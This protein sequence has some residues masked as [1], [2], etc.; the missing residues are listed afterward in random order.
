MRRIGQILPILFIV[1]VLAVAA[2]A[3]IYLSQPIDTKQ[4]AEQPDARTTAEPTVPG[5]TPV[6]TGGGGETQG[7]WFQLY[8]NSPTYPDDPEAHRGGLDEKLVALIDRAQRSVDVAAYDFDLANVADALVRAQGRGVRVRMV[9]DSDIVANDDEAIQA[10]FGKLKA[11]RIPVIEDG[12]KGIMH[13]K[14]TV[15]DGRWVSTGSWNYTDG[16]T[17]RLNNVMIVIESPE[18]ATN[19][20]TEFAKMF[21]RRQFGPTKDKMIPNPVVTIGGSRIETCFASQNRCEDRIVAALSGSTRSIR[22]LAFSFTSTPI[23]QAMLDRRAT[24]VSLAGVFETTGSDTPYSAYGKLKKQGVEV[25]TDGNPYAMHHKA[26]IIDERIVIFGSY[27]FSDNANTN[28]DENLL[29][30]DNPQIARAF[31]AEYERVLAVAKNPPKRK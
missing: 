8:F 17:Y 31:L 14:F 24:G 23:T 28:N 7:G 26:I 5:S 10:A 11:A 27:N 21:E 29:I 13:H 20:S 1:L 12:R 22:F 4:D 25:Y 9:T 6:A 18:L 19:Y 30:V 2:A 16:D 3:L 15:V